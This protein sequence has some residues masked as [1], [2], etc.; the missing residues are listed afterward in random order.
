MKISII[1]RDAIGLFM[2]IQ[3][4]GYREFS[5]IPWHRSPCRINGIWHAVIRHA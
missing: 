5:S 4:M 1:T 2:A 3:N